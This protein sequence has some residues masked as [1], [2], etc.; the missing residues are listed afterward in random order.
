MKRCPRLT[1]AFG[2][3][4]LLA[5]L[6][7]G[8]APAADA[9]IVRI[10]PASVETRT[11]YFFEHALDHVGSGPAIVAVDEDNVVWTAL[12]RSGKLA[13]FANGRFTFYDIGTESRPVG[14][15][16]DR[17]ANGRSGVIWI[18]AAFDD[19][20]VRFD[21][22][23]GRKDVVDLSEDAAW[24]FMVALAPD[25]AVWFTQ[26]A[27]DR[28]GRLDP[29][30]LTVTSIEVPDAGA[31]PAGLAIDQTTGSLWFTESTGDRVRRFDPQS[32]T[33]TTFAMGG[34]FLRH[35]QRPRRHCR[36]PAGRCVVRQARRRTWPYRPRQRYNRD[37]KGA[38]GGAPAGGESPS[39]DMARY[40][41]WHWTA[42]RS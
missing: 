7:D 22:R 5:G 16:P 41:R 26:R 23:S 3:S 6:P 33:F 18:A 1:L 12:A 21:V 28:L 25:G 17:A 42:T 4:L 19:K 9:K 35:D 37:R 14:I 29:K 32:N 38:A 36:R 30:T 40:G 31:S 10:A 27:A 34:E 2:V 15:V 13:R 8:E 20:L 39:T 11:G 24:P